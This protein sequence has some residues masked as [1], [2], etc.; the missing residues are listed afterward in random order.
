MADPYVLKKRLPHFS[1]QQALAR[2]QELLPEEGFGILTTIDVRETMREK[3]DVEFRPY[4]ILGACN[5]SLAHRA[6]TAEPDLGALLPCNVVVMEGEDG[7]AVVSVFKPTAGFTLVDN[8]QLDAVA[9]E[10]EARLTRVRA[11]LE[12]GCA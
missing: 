9:D 2:V 11:R 6:L 1:Y 10:V 8:A 7:G 12:P 3:L 4:T 5:P